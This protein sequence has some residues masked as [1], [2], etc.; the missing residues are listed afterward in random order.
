[1]SRPLTA[2]GRT[3]FRFAAPEV[4][5]SDHFYPGRCSPHTYFGQRHLLIGNLC[6]PFDLKT[7]YNILFLLRICTTVRVRRHIIVR[8]YLSQD[9]TPSRA[10]PRLCK[11]LLRKLWQ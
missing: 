7:M 3:C 5:H 8:F 10:L 11:L 2:I 1:M 9:T 6:V 4:P